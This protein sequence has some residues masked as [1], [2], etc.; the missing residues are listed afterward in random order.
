[1][2]GTRSFTVIRVSSKSKHLD[3]DA[4]KGGIYRSSKPVAAAKKAVSKICFKHGIKG[5]CSITVH[6]RETTRGSA[7]KEYSYI[8]KRILSK[9]KTVVSRGGVEIPFKYNL[10]AKSLKK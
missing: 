3:G 5:V 9:P 1:M 8:V 7:N 4:I 2:S 6:I 10:I